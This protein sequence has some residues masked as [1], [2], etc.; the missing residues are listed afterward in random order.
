MIVYYRCMV[1]R[2]S[3][4]GNS[5]GAL[6]VTYKASATSL[7]HKERLHRRFRRW[8][9]FLRQGREAEQLPIRR[10]RQMMLQHAEQGIGE[11]AGRVC[12]QFLQGDGTGEQL[13]AIVLFLLF[14]FGFGFGFLDFLDEFELLLAE[15]FEV[16]FLNLCAP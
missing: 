16:G 4:A 12:V 2:G 5:G 14:L 11:R 3:P 10:P 7:R 8:L 15:G 6:S 1:V 13:A 9:W